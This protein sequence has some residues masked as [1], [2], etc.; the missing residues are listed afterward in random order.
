[1]YA[2]INLKQTYDSMSILMQYI[3]ILLFCTNQMK[4]LIY[5]FFC[6]VG[7]IESEKSGQMNRY[8]ILGGRHLSGI[9]VQKNFKNAE[10]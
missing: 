4:T 1:M 2:R 9:V 7:N 6:C 10:S 8:L 5:K 3:M